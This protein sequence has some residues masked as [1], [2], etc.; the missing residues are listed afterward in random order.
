MAFS[1]SF[2]CSLPEKKKLGKR[3][4][5]SNAFS[6]GSADELKYFHGKKST[7]PMHSFISECNM[8]FS[9]CV[10]SGIF[11]VFIRVSGG[12]KARLLEN[13]HS[14]ERS[15]N[16]SSRKSRQAQKSYNYPHNPQDSCQ[17]KKKKLSLGKWRERRHHS[18]CLLMLKKS[19][20]SFQGFFFLLAISDMVAQELC[21]LNT[22]LSNVSSLL[23]FSTTDISWHVWRKRY[24]W[25]IFDR[26]LEVTDVLHDFNYL[27]QIHK[28]KIVS[29]Y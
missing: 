14:L 23:H 11:R 2:V 17:K 29:A 24:A 20:F 12:K 27:L 4:I 26:L 5:E 18:F 25:N 28:S 22:N 19:L 16:V 8:N 7:S 10:V 15:Q 21:R 13:W 3:N 1:R 9:N 6:D